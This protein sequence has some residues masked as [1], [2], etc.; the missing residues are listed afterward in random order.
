MYTVNLFFQYILNLNYLKKPLAYSVATVY[1][2][3]TP[4]TGVNVMSYQEV[5]EEKRKSVHYRFPLF[6]IRR[7]RALAKS[8]SMTMTGVLVELVSRAKL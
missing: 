2:V 3:R 4:I 5:E 6:V 7:L 1:T 8:R